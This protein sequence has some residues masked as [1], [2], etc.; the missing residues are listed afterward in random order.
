MRRANFRPTM[1]ERRM[2][3][4][5][6]PHAVIGGRNGALA[7]LALAA[8][9]LLMLCAGRAASA[10]D[11]PLPFALGERLVYSVR[12]ANVKTVGKGTMEVSGPVDVRGTS[13]YLFRFDFQAGFGPVKAVDR[14]ESWFDTRRM[15]SLRFLKHERHPL[16]TEDQSVEMYPEDR[17]WTAADGEAGLSPTDAPLDELSFMYFL[18]TVPLAVDSTYR[19]D[20]HFEAGRNPTTIHVVRRE[21]VKTGAGEFRT[22]LIEMRVKDA[23]H[24]KGDGVIRINLSDDR[25][26]IPVRIESAMPVVGT[27]VLSLERFLP[28][29]GIA[30]GGGGK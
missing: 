27:A 26:R 3:A 11:A 4:R 5:H 9:V 21:T 17:R 10:Q 2:R 14:T 8:L 29:E 12:V 22:L 24:Y 20:R 1:S 15:A 19:F 23:R 13:T 16:S 6:A 25:Q 7:W 30:A 18:R 28:A